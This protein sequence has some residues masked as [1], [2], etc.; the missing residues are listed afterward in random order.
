MLDRPIRILVI[1]D[2]ITY[3]KIIT[4]ILVGMEGVEVVGSAAN[5]K[6]ALD[7]IEQ[8]R[9]DVI[10]LDLAMPE[11]GGPELLAQL[12]MKKLS[13]AVILLTAGSPQNAEE[14]LKMLKAGA[15]DFI[16]KPTGTNVDENMAQLK[17]ELQ[18][19]LKAF[20]RAQSIRD[21]L[22]RPANPPAVSRI[23]AKPAA[24][25]SPPAPIIVPAQPGGRPQI[26]AIGISTGGPQSLNKM[27]PG[28]PANLEVPIVIVQHMPPMFTKPLADDLNKRS[29]LPVCEAQHGQKILPGHIYIAPGG[30]QM[31]LSPGDGGV[32][33]HITDDPPENSCK[34]S[35]DYL[36]RSVAQIYGHNALGVIMTGMG[37]D[38]TLGCRLFKQHGAAILAQDEASC[39]VYGMPKQPVDEG[40][41]DVVAPL[42]KIAQ[43]IVHMVRLGVALCR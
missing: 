33:V 15:F 24:P 20:S 5:G 25:P 14:T 21:I 6:I 18:Q 29:A 31:C 38:G 42:D 7:K 2:A 23:S 30:K 28:L 13:V 37:S 32:F 12:E 36:F 27:V 16:P 39:V 17:R 9:P 35:V 26:V 34:P 41:V 4:S 19:R 3:R 40:L 22:A 43:E 10:T 1:D 8:L 11:M